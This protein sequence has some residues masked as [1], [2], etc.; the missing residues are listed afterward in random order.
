MYDPFRFIPSR[1]DDGL[2]VQAVKTAARKEQEKK[3][4]PEGLARDYRIADRRS[5]FAENS[6]SGP[7]FDDRSRKDEGRGKDNMPPTT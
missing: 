2:V 5:N 1:R 6:T 4:R 3:Q 7:M